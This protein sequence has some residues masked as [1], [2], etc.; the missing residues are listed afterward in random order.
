M[1]DTA[2]FGMYTLE[3]SI[4]QIY[5]HLPY[6]AAIKRCSDALVAPPNFEGII[7][8]KVFSLYFIAFPYS[9]N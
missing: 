7:E 2:V 8:E 5:K 4:L 3:R 9:T 1:I 6:F